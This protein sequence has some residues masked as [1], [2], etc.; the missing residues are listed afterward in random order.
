MPGIVDTNFNQSKEGTREE[1][2]ALPVDRA[3]QIISTMLDQPEFV[4]MDEITFHP[5]HQ[6]F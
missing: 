1:T 5:L 6:D 2:W 4:V 3:A